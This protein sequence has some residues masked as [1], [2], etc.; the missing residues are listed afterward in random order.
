MI[1][2]ENRILKVGMYSLKEADIAQLLPSINRYARDNYGKD[3]RKDIVQILVP[4]REQM[5]RIENLICKDVVSYRV[6]RN[7]LRLEFND[8]EVH[9]ELET[10]YGHESVIAHCTNKQR[11]Y[12]TISMLLCGDV[13]ITTDEYIIDRFI[14]E[15]NLIG[16]LVT[17]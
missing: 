9:L 12:R 15:N 4:T 11:L 10:D 6:G 1:A 7:E 16:M 3:S 8:Y 17:N 5:R 14:K 2:K 13:D